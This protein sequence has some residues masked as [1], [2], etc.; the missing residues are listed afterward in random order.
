MTATR[1]APQS[2]W[3]D[4]D[5]RRYAECLQYDGELFF[6]IGETGPAV[7]Q[8][9]EAKLVCLRCDVRARCLEY[10]LET[11]QEF[12]VWGAKSEKERRRI[13]RQRAAERAL[14]R[15]GVAS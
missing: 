2:E 14:A 15:Q 5:W 6:P 3:D 7:L 11:R 8:I 4:P 12:G 9:E 13:L 10:A 1:H